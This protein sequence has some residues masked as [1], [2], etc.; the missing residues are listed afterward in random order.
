MRPCFKFSA[1]ADGQPAVLA[2]D[3]EIGFWGTQAA[4]FRA[5]LAN[6]SGSDLV[7]EINS[8]GGDVMAGLGIYNML[9][10]FAASGTS[11][12]TRVTGIAASIASVI[13]LAGDQRLMPS[14]S[15]ALI[16]QVG[17]LAFGVYSA[18]ELRDMADTNDKITS[19]LRNIYVDRMGVTAEKADELMS[20]D[21]YLTAQECLDLGF[22]TALTDEI[23]ATAKFNLAR[24]DLPENVGK[25]FRNQAAEP[26]QKPEPGTAPE[27]KP[28]PD[29]EP[30]AV[31]Q[32]PLAEQIV[33]EAKAHGF[34]ALA[35]FFAVNFD[36]FGKAKTRIAEARE[37]RS[38]CAI[39]GCKEF[40]D[41][42]IRAGKGMADVRNELISQLAEADEHTDSTT[43]VNQQE[44]QTTGKTAKP[45][46]VNTESI[47]A[48]HNK[49]SKK[50]R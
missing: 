26:E 43:P 46:V 31:P 14:N 34:E 24:A 13:A 37:I 19:S 33:A 2:L 36:D 32:T 38:V 40:A 9:R 16:H 23:R 12:T 35:P 21:N 29:P 18:D 27:Q 4:D 3:D 17:S 25:V 50:G 49:Q 39:A 8:P 41:K 6:V 48:S 42:A 1:Q 10:H 11:V 47:W 5:Q 45:A 15:F 20:K 7:V 44:D 28:E 30:E 22:A